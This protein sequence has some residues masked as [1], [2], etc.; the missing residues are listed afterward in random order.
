MK[1]LIVL[2]RDVE[3]LPSYEKQADGLLDS[4]EWRPAGAAE[5]AD[6]EL[7][8]GSQLGVFRIVGLL[9]A[10][11]MGKVYRATDAR[12]NRDVAIKMLPAK[13][14]QQPQ[15]LARFQREA[16]ALAA[17][18]HPHICALYDV[19]PH[20]LVMELI[21]GPTLAE[22]IRRCPLACQEALNIARQ[23]AE[24]LEAA[25]EKGIVHRDLKPTNIKVT[26]AGV[27]KVLDF[28]LAAVM[29]GSVSD[30]DPTNSP[31]LTMTATQAGTIMGTAAYMSPE[32]ARG[33]SVD[34][35]S[36]IWAFGVV[37]YELLTGRRPFHGEGL[38]ETLASVMK[39]TP[40][41][42]SVPVQARRLIEG[43]LEKD[44]KKRLRDI[45][46]AWRLL[47]APRSPRSPVSLLDV[48][49]WHGAPCG[50]RCGARL[51]ASR[52]RRHF[53]ECSRRPKA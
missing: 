31:T 51:T 24:A 7:A 18:S 4:P 23:I 15:W 19:G 46:D 26:P 39:H 40:D 14:A 42:S 52:M 11:E 12:L 1:S 22:R 36:D 41:L 50:W 47:R 43:C 5:T 8:P 21:E 45:G 30:S 16:R 38:I 9:G 44:P 35:R 17:L 28:G 20:Y 3:S 48:P 33:V 49:S 10:G 34:K 25:H 27:V 53:A 6:S 37:L 29:R 13:Y 2:R 32:Q